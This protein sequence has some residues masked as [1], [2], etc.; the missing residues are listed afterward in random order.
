MQE[1]VQVH[2]NGI[3]DAF[4]PATSQRGVG[5]K[6]WRTGDGQAITTIEAPGVNHLEELQ[7]NPTAE[8]NFGAMR[9]IF[10]NNIFSG[11]IDPVFRVDRR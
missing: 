9:N 11:T 4:I 5:S 1:C 10:N 3:S 2:N 8:N 7:A 6:S